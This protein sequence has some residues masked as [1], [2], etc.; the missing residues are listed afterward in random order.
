MFRGVD[1]PDQ[2]ARQRGQVARSPQSCCPTAARK[3]AI[4][5]PARSPMSPAR[6][7][8]SRCRAPT[9]ACGA[10][11][12]AAARGRRRH[13]PAGRAGGVPRRSRRGD[14][15]AEIQAQARRSRPWPAAQ[16]RRRG[17]GR[18]RPR[19]S[20]R[21]TSTRK[22]SAGG[23]MACGSTA[24]R[25]TGRRSSSTCAAAGLI[26]TGS[27]AF[28]SAWRSHPE[29]YCK[30]VGRRLP[31]MLAAVVDLMGRHIATHRT[32]LA[33]DGKG[34]WTKADL[35]EPKKVLGSF[36]GG[37]IPLWKGA[38]RKSMAELEPG[39]DVYASKGSR[40]AF[41]RRSPSPSCASSP[42]SRSA[43]S[44]RSSCP[45]GRPAGDHR[46]ARHQSENARGARARDRRAA[47]ARPRGVAHAAAGRRERRQRSFDGGISGMSLLIPVGNAC[48][49]DPGAFS[50]RRDPPRLHSAPQGS[51]P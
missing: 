24:K 48:S 1:R 30:E 47:G 35:E 34:G 51:R 12:R 17:G 37:F 10:I 7:S 44:A 27:A 20:A 4:G 26:S 33:P 45:A 13:Y 36:K 32:W 31:A 50:A 15:L 38:C 18:Q 29:L 49:A 9:R 42:A 5:G 19:R 11:M 43:T 25:S 3:A 16:A 21:P 23:R 2:G 40:T 41:A 8:R 14:R 46:P 28:P 22:P 39:T 6:A